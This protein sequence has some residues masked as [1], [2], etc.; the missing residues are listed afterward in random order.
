MPTSGTARQ[1]PTRPPSAAPDPERDDDGKR[2]QMQG[3][4]DEPRI[5]GVVLQQ[6]QRAEEQQDGHHAFRR[7]RRCHHRDDERAGERHH[8]EQARGDPE[9]ARICT[10][11]AARTR[12]SRSANNRAGQR[13]GPACRPRARLFRF[14]RSSLPRH[15]RCGVGRTRVVD[16]RNR[17]QRVSSRK[18]TTGTT[19]SQ[20]T[21]RRMPATLDARGRALRARRR[22]WLAASLLRP[23]AGRAVGRPTDSYQRSRRSQLR[24]EPG[25]VL[26]ARARS[27]APAPRR[28]DG[29][30][31]SRAEK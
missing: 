5:D 31:R 18:A 27:S 16:R 8:F 25:G 9:R 3:A 23:A 20:G 28:G 22:A 13:P 29:R 19:E 24:D 12:P 10:P 17:V 11:Q 14:R 2:M 7:H 26:R 15:C 30:R 1:M 4:A 21:S 6:T